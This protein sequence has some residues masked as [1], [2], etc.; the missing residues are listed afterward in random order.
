MQEAKRTRLQVLPGWQIPSKSLWFLHSFAKLSHMFDVLV[1]FVFSKIVI[2]QLN[3][4]KNN[5]ANLEMYVKDEVKKRI[6][7]HKNK[8]NY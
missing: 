7:M 8:S 6:K 2:I 1:T 5:Y 3:Y 4:S